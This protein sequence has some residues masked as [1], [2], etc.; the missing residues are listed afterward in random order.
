MAI[1]EIILEVL[2]VGHWLKKVY[3]DMLSL[4]VATYPG[5]VLKAAHTSTKIQNS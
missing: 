5:D 2:S 4:G 1:A 3:L